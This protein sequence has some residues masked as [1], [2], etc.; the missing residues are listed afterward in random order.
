M[1][2]ELRRAAHAK[3]QRERYRAIK[4]GQPL[5]TTPDKARA[6]VLMLMEAGFRCRELE[7]ATGVANPTMR[8]IIDGHG[9]ITRLTEERILATRQADVYEHCREV[10]TTVPTRMIRALTRLGWGPGEIARTA[11]VDIQTVRTLRDC[12]RERMYRTT[13]DCIGRAYDQMVAMPQPGGDYANRVRLYARSRGWAPPTS[14]GWSV[15]A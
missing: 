7:R 11:G 8:N 13:A 1:T 10:P 6:H 3:Y 5:T 15:A 4:E 12:P 14:D 2:P 9:R